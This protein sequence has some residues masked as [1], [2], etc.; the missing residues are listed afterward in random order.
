MEFGQ[1][2][3]AFDF[4]RLGENRIVVRRVK[5]GEILK[6]LDEEERNLTSDMLVIADAEK[7][8]ALAGVMGGFDSEITESDG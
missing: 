1:P 5:A 3:H 7:P 8:V 4:H 2:L 6:T